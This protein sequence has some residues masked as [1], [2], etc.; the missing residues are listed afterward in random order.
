MIE[1]GVPFLASERK[2]YIRLEVET[3]RIVLDPVL[4]PLDQ[5]QSTSTL[6]ASLP[7]P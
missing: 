7:I 6:L 1:V 2:T 3:G 5:T 4:L